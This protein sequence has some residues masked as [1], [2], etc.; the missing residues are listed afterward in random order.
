MALRVILAGVSRLTVTIIAKDEATRIADALTSVAWA[1]ERLVIDS[2]SRDDTVAIATPLATRVEVRPWP[3][4]GAQKNA[5]ADLATHDWILSLDADE[6]VT[7]SLAAEIQRVLA[8]PS[9]AAAYRMPRV[10]WYLGHWIRTTDWYPDR[11]PRLYDRRRARWRTEPVHESLEVDGAI[12]DLA[13]E[14]EHRPYDDVSDHLARMDTYTTLAARQMLT[15]GRVAR[16]R[17]LLGHPVA[18]F[19]RNYIARGGF[20]Q[21]T[22][23]LVVS[24]LNATYVLLKFVKLFELQASSRSGDTRPP[25]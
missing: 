21:G 16:A 22:T 8:D 9:P 15:R 5:A 2:G 1:D 11:A 14:L 17:H 19:F 23:G 20:R 6:R 18:A 3:G 25:R 10:T 24:L 7:P 12:A 4:Y 13:G